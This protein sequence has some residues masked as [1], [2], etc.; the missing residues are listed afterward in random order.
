MQQVCSTVVHSC[1]QG[2]VCI[3]HTAAERKALHISKGAHLEQLPHVLGCLPS[4]LANG[5]AHP[6]AVVVKALNA[7]VVH[8][9]VMS[10]GRLVEMAGVIVTDRDPV[11][12][13]IHILGPTVQQYSAAVQ[14]PCVKGPP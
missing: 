3:P 5:G 6:G 2:T 11:P 4:Y 9:A 12:I 8:R 10:P 7:V 13:D 1:I 14:S